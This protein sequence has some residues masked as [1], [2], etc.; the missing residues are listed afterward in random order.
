VVNSGE[1]T[2]YP[3]LPRYI[4]CHFADE[5]TVVEEE[6]VNVVADV[7]HRV[8]DCDIDF[9]CLPL[10]NLHEHVIVEAHHLVTDVM[11]AIGVLREHLLIFIWR[12]HLLP[13][14][15]CNISSVSIIDVSLEIDG[16]V[17]GYATD[18]P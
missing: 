1:T 18:E 6:L 15:G 3:G 8:Q 5:G 10:A 11:R 12:F 2:R 17:L 16:L 7:P 4:D 14:Y 9:D 13:Q